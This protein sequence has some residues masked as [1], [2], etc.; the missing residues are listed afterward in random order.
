M[1]EITNSEVS[2]IGPGE[3]YCPTCGN[4]ILKLAEI[5][6]KCGVR[7]TLSTNT[8]QPKSKTAAVL[9]AVFLGFWTW[10]Y[11]YRNDSWKFWLNLSLVIFSL[12]FWGII[13]WV[14]AIIDV[15]VKPSS[16]YATYPNNYLN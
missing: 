8:V 14:W 11:T 15:S 4:T 10:L 12:G 13:A 7:N 3:M 9:L 2:K 16:Y 6:P 5:C 1:S